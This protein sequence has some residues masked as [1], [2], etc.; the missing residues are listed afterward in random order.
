MGI[1]TKT[2]DK[3]KTTLFNLKTKEKIFVSKASLRIEAIGVLDEL[4]SALGLVKNRLNIKNQ[5]LIEKIQTDLF[6]L[7]SILAGADFKFPSQKTKYLENK[8][9]NLEKFL[10]PLRNF[11]IPG[12]G[13]TASLLHLSRSIARRAE[14]QAV[15][16]FNEE[17][18]KPSILKYLNRLSDTLFVLARE[19]NYKEKI[20]ERVWKRA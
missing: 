1:Y 3:G 4:N 2:G 7:G 6:I 13:E 14:R 15:K 20:K 8:I 19:A 5:Q 18:V 17:K 10:P 9:D 16:L 11:V 12:G